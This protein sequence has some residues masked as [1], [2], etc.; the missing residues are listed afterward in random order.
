MVHPECNLCGNRHPRDRFCGSRRMIRYHGIAVSPS[1]ALENYSRPE[2]CHSCGPMDNV[3]PYCQALF[4]KTEV[5][6]C[7][8]HGKFHVQTEFAIPP[9]LEALIQIPHFMK[10]I[11][12][13]N[14]AVAMASVG[15]NCRVLPGGPSTMILSGRAYHQVSG[16]MFP[17][18]GWSP[19][20]AQI[21]LLDPDDAVSA[22]MESQHQV[23]MPILLESLQSIMMEHNPWVQQFCQAASNMQPLRWRWDGADDNDAMLLGALIAEPG[24]HRNIV[25]QVT[26]RPPQCI[27]DYHRLYHPLAYPILFPTGQVGWHLGMQSQDGTRMTRVD[28]LKYVLMRRSTISHLQRCQKLTLEFYCDAWASVEAQLMEFHRR[29]QQQNLYRTASR[30]ALCDQLN[31]ADAADIGVPVRTILPA[32][33]VGS[34]R[35]YHTLFLNSM[36]LPRRFGK[37]DLFITMTANR[38]WDEINAVIPAG[39]D[40]EHHPDIVARVFMLKVEALIDD[41]RQRHIFGPVAAFVWRVEWQKRG[42]PHLHLLVILQ[43]HIMTTADIDSVVSAEIPNP[44]TDPLLHAMVSKFMLH[45]PCDSCAD[46]ACR[47]RNADG[48][49]YR[50]FPKQMAPRTSIAGDKFPVYRRRGR[51][52]TSIKDYAGNDRIVTD[53]WVVPYSPYLLARYACHCNVEVAA[54]VKTFKYLYKYVLKPPDS[55]GIVIDEI[56][57][58]LNGRL[59]SA[60][61]AVFRI[62]GLRLHAEWPP[63]MCLDIHLPDHERMV[64]DPTASPE[65]LLMQSTAVSS[66]LKAWF[67]LNIEDVSARQYLYTEIPEHY[68]WN[69]SARSWKKRSTSAISVARTYAVSPHHVEL[70]ALR[71]LLNIVRG[72]VSWLCLLNVD[73]FIYGTF[74]ETCIARGLMQDDTCAFSAFAEIV[75]HTTSTVSIC[76]Q[77]AMYLL[78]AQISEPVRMFDMFADDMC[79]GNCTADNVQVALRCIDRY[80]RQRGSRIEDFGFESCE[81]LGGNANVIDWSDRE[82]HQVEYENI[83]QEA[84]S[85]CSD[86]QQSA[87]DVVMSSQQQNVF[88]IQGGAGTGKTKWVNCVTAALRVQNKKVL[89]VASSAL[90]ASLMTGGRTAHAALGIPVPTTENSFCHW[91][92]RAKHAMRDIDVIIWDEMS[93]IHRDVADC[94][95]ASLQDIHSHQQPFGGKK[96]IFVGDFK[97]L[98]P[99]VRRGKGEYATIHRCRWWNSAAKITF[100]KNWRAQHDANYTAMLEAVGSGSTMNV[101]VPADSQ[102]ESVAELT[103]LMFGDNVLDDANSANMIL[104]LRLDDAAA[105]NNTVMNQIPEVAQSATATDVFPTDTHHLPTEFVASLQIPGAPPHDLS[106]KKGARYS[107]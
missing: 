72:A 4:W 9:A 97:Q 78:N 28:Y 85:E 83:F 98:P 87:V 79:G 15:H 40:W 38:N 71:L 48:S 50:C 52:V 11:R 95:D 107:E 62:L 19:K 35:F 75:Q 58:Y 43:Q 10:H 14:M 49:C 105:I 33:V 24:E 96:M 3:C 21:Y 22:R 59:L 32:S 23:L 70:Y 2:L 61:E 29:P 53:E 106:L 26:D 99:V 56:D 6:R 60:S 91:D 103:S 104:A 64:F 69:S 65:D 20:F 8:N 25:I 68:V 77:F 94:V 93:M 39:A 89:C 63:V 7:C 44:D 76:E 13:Y 100:T 34:P 74:Q 30:A 84:Y 80:L 45:K 101:Q 31:H 5:I 57:T 81:I 1:G 41:I 67:Q 54:H 42:M 86:E 37:P 47:R 90:A 82:Q 55:A 18:N 102:C 66:M 27:P 73:G 92:A 36:A 88:V 51:F 16:G 46:A 12:Q 17:G